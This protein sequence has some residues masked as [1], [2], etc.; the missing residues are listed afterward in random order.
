[1]HRAVH[2]DLEELLLLLRRK[3]PF[4]SDY[5]AYLILVLADLFTVFAFV[6]KGSLVSSVRTTVSTGSPWGSA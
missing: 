2:R 3:N 4:H 5:H 1:V 6:H